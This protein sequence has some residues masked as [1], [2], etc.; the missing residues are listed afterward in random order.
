MKI[1]S[2]KQ[3][4][5]LIDKNPDRSLDC[6]VLLN[7]GLRSSKSITFDG[8]NYHIYN[9]I[10]DSE[11]IIKHDKLMNSFPIGD[12]IKKGTLYAY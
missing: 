1:L 7:Y 9:E 6:F 5:R 8:D 10:G 4:D 2:Q 11:N 3:L 12:A